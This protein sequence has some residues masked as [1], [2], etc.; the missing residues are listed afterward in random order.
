[1]PTTL[2]ISIEAV[3]FYKTEP[4]SKA[5]LISLLN[6]SGS[7]LEAALASL[8]ERLAAGAT[9]LIEVHDTVQLVSA[10]ECAALIERLRADE[11]S[12]DIGKD[13]KS[14]V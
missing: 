7:E 9:R 11:L 2:D 4:I 12:R 8:R 1:M 14:V 5:T 6:T 13:R 10:P 3:L